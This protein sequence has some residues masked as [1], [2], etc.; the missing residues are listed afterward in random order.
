MLSKYCSDI[1]DKYS[2]KVSGVNELVPNLGNKSR[3][4]FHYRNFQ[5]YLQLRMKL[6]GIYKTLEFKQSDQLKK[7]ISFNT[8]KRRILSKALKKI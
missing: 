2:I 7:N 4:I 1:A 8:D 6:V 3:Y 5:L